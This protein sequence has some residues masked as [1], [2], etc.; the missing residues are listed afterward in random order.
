MPY[1]EGDARFETIAERER[2][3]LYEEFLRER[4]KQ[5]KEAIWQA[6]KENMKRFRQKLEADR[7]IT[8]NSQWRKVNNTHCGS[9]VLQIKEQF[10]E[11]ET[12]KVLDKMDRLQVFEDYIRG[13]EREEEDKKRE[14][15]YHK[16]R[17][18]R[19]NRDAY[20]VVYSL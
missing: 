15:L 7:S 20:R 17:A 9:W 2:E 8:V 4:E 13:L 5:E 18:S 12:F 19:K 1:F 3:E 16:K 10:K 11:D 14:E 6:K